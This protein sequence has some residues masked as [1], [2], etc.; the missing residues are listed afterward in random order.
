MN[1]Q[2]P[3]PDDDHEFKWKCAKCDREGT[4]S[5]DVFWKF[6]PYCGSPVDIFFKCCFC[7]KIYRDNMGVKGERSLQAHINA[8]HGREGRKPR[9]EGS[10]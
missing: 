6:C 3:K 7:G 8:V 5:E 4:V 10:S 9:K 1:A 2:P